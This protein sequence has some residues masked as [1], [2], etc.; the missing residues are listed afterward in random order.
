MTYILINLSI[1]DIG[2]CRDT[3]LALKPK[4]QKDVGPVSPIQYIYRDW[5]KEL[6]PNEVDNG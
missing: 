4:V 1:I 6:D 2:A 3:F 5:I